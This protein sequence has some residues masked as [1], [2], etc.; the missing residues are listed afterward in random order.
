MVMREERTGRG[1]RD[2]DLWIFRGAERGRE[3][4]REGMIGRERR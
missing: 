3:R 1:D 4:E 2:R